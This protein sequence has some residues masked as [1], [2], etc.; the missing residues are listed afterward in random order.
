MKVVVAGGSGFIG[1]ALVR[2]LADR[3]DKVVVLSR[4]PGRDEGPVRTVHWTAGSPGPWQDEVRT[5]DAVLNLAGEP[6]ADARW[7]DA[8]K[9]E[10]EQSRVVSASALS[11]ILA[12]GGHQVKVLVNVSAVGFYGTTHGDAPLDE[13]TPPGDDFLARVCVARE[14]AAEPA[15]RGI[16]RVCHARM[17]VVLGPD[18]GVLAKM[19][20]PFKA[21]VGGPI[22][23]G[24]QAIPWVH[25]RDAV[26]A[27][28][29]AVDHAELDGPFNVTA[30]EPATMNDFARTLGA[31]LGR[32]SALRVPGAA[33]RLAMG[34]AADMVLKGQRAIPKR[35]ADLGFAFVF[36]D[37]KSALVDAID[38]VRLAS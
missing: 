38:R 2:E 6:V 28:L 11:E 15:R 30:P 25:R 36:P 21:F 8:R 34:E 18:G 4:G 1:R 26:R 17:G 16:V 35:L 9:R 10:I 33:L 20:P 37:L 22:G 5:A 29:F 31:V 3:G 12:A 19:V 7:T 32:P 24:K 14:A 13:S 27:L 23:D